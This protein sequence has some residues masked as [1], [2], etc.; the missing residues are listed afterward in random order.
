MLGRA[1]EQAHLGGLGQPLGD[2][3][4]LLIQRSQIRGAGDIAAHGAIEIG[5]AQSNTV[6]GDG[7][8]QNGDAVGGSLCGLQGGGSVCHDQVNAC[9]NKAVGDGGA[10]CGIVL[11]VLEV[12][13]DILAELCGQSILKALSG[14]VQSGVLHQLADANGILLAVSRCGRSRSRGSG[15]RSSRGAGGTAAGSQ[16]SSC[17]ADSGGRQERTTRNFTHDITPSILL[18]RQQDT[19]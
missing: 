9:G 4:R 6:L 1:V 12:K 19:A 2:H 10:G 15:G 18:S 3:I 11:G 8:A 5:Q 16:G 13:G 17:A 7:G 14:S